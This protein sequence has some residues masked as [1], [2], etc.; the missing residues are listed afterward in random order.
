MKKLLIILISI[1]ICKKTE[2]VYLHKYTKKFPVSGEGTNWDFCMAYNGAVARKDLKAPY[3]W[4]GYH[5]NLYKCKNGFVASFANHKN[6]TPADDVCSRV[7]WKKKGRLVRKL[8]GDGIRSRNWSWAYYGKIVGNKY[9]CSL[10]ASSNERL[11][12]ME[13]LDPEI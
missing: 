5:Y 7:L 13:G 2:T 8:K 9:L 4:K 3:R 6:A 1:S 11:P 12:I 10:V